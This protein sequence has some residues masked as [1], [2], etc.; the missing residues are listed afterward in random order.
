MSALGMRGGDVEVEFEG[1]SC[2]IV[3]FS[4]AMVGNGVGMESG[5]SWDGGLDGKT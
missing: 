4:S 2:S 1:E 3:G 5:R